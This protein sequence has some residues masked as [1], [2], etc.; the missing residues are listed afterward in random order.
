MIAFAVPVPKEAR[1]NAVTL[2]AQTGHLG[3]WFSAD[4]MPL[5]RSPP[6]AHAG[7]LCD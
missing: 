4:G 7:G 3:R 2:R 1:L 5:T 6:V